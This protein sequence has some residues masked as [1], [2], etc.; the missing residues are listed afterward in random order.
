M[1][2]G[3]T[4]VAYVAAAAAFICLLVYLRALSCGFVN[5]EDQDYVINNI[6]IRS[7][8]YGMFAWAFTSTPVASFWLPLTYISFAIDYH[9]WGLD[10]LGYHL[11]NILLHASNTG[12]IVLI[13]DQM[14]CSKSNVDKNAQ[15]PLWLYSAMLL[16]AALLFGL[17]PLRVESVAWVTERRGVLNGLFTL[18]AMFF[19]LRFQHKRDQAEGHGNGTRDYLLSL[20]FFLFSLM[21]KPT[22]IVLP[23]ILLILDWYPLGRLR[24][25]RMVRVLAEKVPYLLL[26]AAIISIPV[27]IKVKEGSFYPLDSFPMSLR[28]IAAGNALFEYMRLTFYPVDIVPY[29]D[30]PHVIPRIY[31]AKGLVVAMFLGLCIFWYKKWPWL[32]AMALCFIIPIIP[33]LHLFAGGL[34]I[35]HASRYTYLSAIV[36]SIISSA[37]LVSAYRRMP[38]LRSR[39]GLVLLAGMIMALLCFYMAT[40]Q[41]LISSWKDS[42]AMWTRVIEYQAFDKAYF[43]RGLF[44]VDNGDYP[45][46]I[47][48]YTTYIAIAA[49]QKQPDIFNLYAFRGEA[50]TRAGLHEEAVKDFDVAISMFPHTRYFHHRAAS[51]LALDRVN[52]ANADMA[53][54][55]RSQGQIKWILPGSRL[56]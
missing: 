45:A 42:G 27:I 29:Y 48:D 56:D 3:N 49:R 36:P 50:Y 23:A 35:V 55:G 21:S 47:R 6:G 20:L 17:H 7:L 2:K 10:P 38:E 33:T 26:S 39:R 32:T 30:L 25:W 24:R 9:F 53:R 41:R 46:A 44:Y 54:A 28:V 11:T 14:Y 40:S 22:S 19:Y 51:L 4:S 5:W 37:L 52:E 8:N 16:F 31:I 15:E 34:Q 12:L 18:I 13:A 1:S 43:Y